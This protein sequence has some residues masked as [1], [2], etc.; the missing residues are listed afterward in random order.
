MVLWSRDVEDAVPYRLVGGQL[1]PVP[2][3]RAVLVRLYPDKFRPAPAG[4]VVI[5]ARPA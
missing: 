1:L 5:L 3:N 4:R 2:Q